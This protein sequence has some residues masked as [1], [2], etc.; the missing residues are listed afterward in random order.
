MHL[1]AFAA[2]FMDHLVAVLLFTLR[3]IQMQGKM[4]ERKTRKKEGDHPRTQP[5]VW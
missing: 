1:A 3:H 4:M 2:R 5:P